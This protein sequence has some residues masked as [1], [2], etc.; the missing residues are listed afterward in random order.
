MLL[1]QH[2][3][4]G[5]DGIEAAWPYPEEIGVFEEDEDEEVIFSRRSGL[6][7]RGGDFDQSG[8]LPPV[9]ESPAMTPRVRRR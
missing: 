2:A 7:S 8:P 6:S 3:S 1:S 5:V 4:D 9:P